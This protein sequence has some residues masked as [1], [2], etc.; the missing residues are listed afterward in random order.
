M[1]TRAL[2]MRMRAKACM[3]A[4]GAYTIIGKVRFRLHFVVKCGTI[5]SL[6]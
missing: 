6:I 1:R 5:M 4:A 2:Y 3:R